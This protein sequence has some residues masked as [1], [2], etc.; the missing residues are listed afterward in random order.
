M[1]KI[2]I[3]DNQLRLPDDRIITFND[4]QYEAIQLIRKWLKESN[5]LNNIFTL[6]GFGGSGKTTVIKKILDEYDGSIVEIGRASCRER[7]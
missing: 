2:V 7:V 3:E 5:G 4:Q 6:S 1:A